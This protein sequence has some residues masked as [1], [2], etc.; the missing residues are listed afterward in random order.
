MSDEPTA[1]DYLVDAITDMPSRILTPEQAAN[2]T[3]LTVTF[4]GNGRRDQRI[5]L[6][7]SDGTNTYLI[8]LH[9]NRNRTPR[10]LDNGELDPEDGWR[11]REASVRISTP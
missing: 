4:H 7:G 3:D 11:W 10:K 5:H 9:R 2:L 1:H 6:T 8:E